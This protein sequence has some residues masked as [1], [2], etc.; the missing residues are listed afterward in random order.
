MGFDFQ[1]YGRTLTELGY[2]P[3]NSEVDFRRLFS[4]FMAELAPALVDRVRRRFVGNWRE[5]RDLGDYVTLRKLEFVA[6]DPAWPIEH[7]TI[8]HDFVA[9]IAATA[10]ENYLGPDDISVTLPDFES[11]VA[12][13]RKLIASNH[14][15][16]ASLIRAWCRK[17]GVGRPPLMDMADPQPLVRALHDKGLIDFEA[18]RGKSLPALLAKVEAWPRDMPQTDAIEDLDLTVADL[19]H[20]ELEAREAR[21]KADAEK[22]TIKFGGEPL[23]TGRDGFAALFEQLADAALAQG[24]DW[25]NR[26]RPPRLTIQEQSGGERRHPGLGSGK[27]QAWRNQPPD[28]VRQAMGIDLRMACPRISPPASP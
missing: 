18:A 1:G 8:D 13:N 2:P 11:V 15:K 3:L 21:R 19:Q 14:A 7:E 20:D 6:F 5:G 23:D 16:L 4:V 10:A 22:R 26:S 9:R 24:S 28:S 27:G 17:K 25:F 12:A